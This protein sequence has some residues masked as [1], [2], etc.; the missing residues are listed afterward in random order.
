VDGWARGGRRVGEGWARG[1]LITSFNIYICHVK[2]LHRNN[3][4]GFK[5]AGFFLKCF[6]YEVF[7]KQKKRKR[8]DIY[9]LRVK[10]SESA[11]A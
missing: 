2:K 3:Y 9:Y 4:D 11:V 8:S 7:V 5:I 6:C 1:W 10:R